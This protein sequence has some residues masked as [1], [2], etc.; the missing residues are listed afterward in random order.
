MGCVAGYAT[1]VDKEI[2][3]VGEGGR[4]LGS[5][6]ALGEGEGNFG[7]DALDFFGRDDGSGRGDEFAG[8]I[9]GAEAADRGVSVRVTETVGLQMGGLGAAASIGKGKAAKGESEGVLALARH[10]KSITKVISI[11]K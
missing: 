5:D 4:L 6:Q 7:E 3:E 8:K 10:L 11:Y 2:A 9:G 1:R